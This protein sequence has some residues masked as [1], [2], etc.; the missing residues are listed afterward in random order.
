MPLTKA[1]L[2]A[3]LIASRCAGTR[4]DGSVLSIGEWLAG[5]CS[6]CDSPLDEAKLLMCSNEACE[7]MYHI[8]CLDPPLE[9]I[10][11]EDQDWY[12]PSCQAIGVGS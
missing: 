10:P 1:A 6:V 2:V 3:G 8:Y 11:P 4:A 9:K 5:R 12:C 7:Q